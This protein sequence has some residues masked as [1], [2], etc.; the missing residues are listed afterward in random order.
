M[1]SVS[2]SSDGRKRVIFKSPDGKRH[3]L[4]LGKVAKSAATEIGRHV[5]HLV[6]CCRTGEEPKESTQNWSQRIPSDWPKVYAKLASLGLLNNGHKPDEV[7]AD[8]VEAYIASRRDVK[9]GTLKTWSQASQKVR[10][11]FG[12]RTLKSLTVKD[13]KDFLRW[14]K[15]P[16]EQ[17]GAGHKG[18][19][20]SKHLGHVRGFLNEAVDAQIIP[21]NPFRKVTANRTPQAGR[22]KVIPTEDVLQ[23]I[24]AAPDAEM[25]ALIALSFWGGL[26]TP[27]EHFVLKWGAI[28]WDE[29]MMTVLSPKTER[30]GKEQRDT[31]L[32]PELVPYLMDLHEVSANTSPDDYV[33]QKRRNQSEANLRGRMSRIIRRAGFKPWPKIFQNLRSTRQTI[34]EKFYPRGTICA[35]MGNTEDIAEAHYVQEMEEFRASAAQTPTTEVGHRVGAVHYPDT[36]SVEATRKTTQHLQEPVSTAEK[37]S[38]RGNRLEPAGSTVFPAGSQRFSSVLKGMIAPQAEEDGNRTHQ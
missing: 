9:P 30:V 22:K 2:T 24:N 8:F 21:A 6:R 15:T 31:P 29:G 19:T 16:K 38:R 32:F 27:S 12:Q 7:F 23:V 5:E 1:A 18:E 25:K 10:T 36:N 17:G 11:F 34:L 37:P 4:Y 14:L 33:I 13:G 35:W 26:R 3:T 20:P 28:R